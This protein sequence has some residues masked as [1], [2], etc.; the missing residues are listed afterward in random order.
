MKFFRSFETFSA[1]ELHALRLERLAMTSLASLLPLK[2]NAAIMDYK[3]FGSVTLT[4]TMVPG[5][6]YF[7]TVGTDDLV[8]VSVN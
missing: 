1:G 8:P 6:F 3:L 7:G 4:N 5:G 2:P